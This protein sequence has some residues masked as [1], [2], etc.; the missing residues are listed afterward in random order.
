MSFYRYRYRGAAHQSCNVNYKDSRIISAIFHNLSGCDSHF[1]ISNLATSFEG[2]IDLLP[3][4]KERYISFTKHVDDTKV[5][6]RFIDS[7]MLMPSSLDKLASYLNNNEKNVTI[8]Y[9]RKDLE[10]S[11]LTRKDVFPY[12]YIDNWSKLDEN[13]LPPKEVFYSELNNKIIT[14]EDYEHASKVWEVFNV[15]SLGEYSDLYLRTDVLLL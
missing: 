14:E 2:R 11:L 1:L 5:K 13:Q 15:Q 12:E 6:L 3:I 8:K 4:N 10:F 7:F 9:C